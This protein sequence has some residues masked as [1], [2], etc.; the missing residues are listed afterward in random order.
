MPVQIVHTLYINVL[1]NCMITCTRNQH[2]RNHHEVSMAFPKGL[3]VACSKEVSLCRWHAPKDWHF[4]S[5][6]LLTIGMFQ[7]MLSGIFPR[8]DVHLCEILVC[9][10]LPGLSA[11]LAGAIIIII[12]IV[13]I[14]AIV[15]V[16][17]IITMMYH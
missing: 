3:S 2:L 17:M 15:I 7:W 12:I 16:I 13:T 6:E 14:I 1:H 8:T 11:G 4:S 9:N 10:L 5:G